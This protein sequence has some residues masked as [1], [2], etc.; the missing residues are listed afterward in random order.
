MVLMVLWGLIVRKMML[1]ISI[2]TPAV[3]VAGTTA[4]VT[5]VVRQRRESVD[6]AFLALSLVE[7]LLVL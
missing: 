2:F 5:V 1:L 7:L 3:I 6:T 4:L